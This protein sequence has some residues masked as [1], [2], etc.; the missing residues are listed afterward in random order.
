VKARMMPETSRRPT[1][2]GAM[3]GRL[4]SAMPGR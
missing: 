1:Q 3:R 2:P 4:L